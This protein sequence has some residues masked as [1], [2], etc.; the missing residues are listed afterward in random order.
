V[1]KKNRNNGNNIGRPETRC[2]IEEGDAEID[3]RDPARCCPEVGR[4]I[5][6]CGN[7][8]KIRETMAL[9]YFEFK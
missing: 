5:C 1:N 9:D 6:L 2:A 7:T 8:I 3:Q 4:A